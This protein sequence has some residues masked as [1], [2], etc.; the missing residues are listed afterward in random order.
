MKYLLENEIQ[1]KIYFPPVHLTT[2]YRNLF[3]YKGEEFTVAENLSK[4]V[5]SLPMY[6]ALKKGEM[7]YIV[8][9][10]EKFIS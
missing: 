5:L 6:P 10:I 7:D 3:G 2:L 8:E 9:K 4:R 1:T